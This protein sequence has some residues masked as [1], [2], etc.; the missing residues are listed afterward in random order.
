MLI[1]SSD[2]NH[3]PYSY[4]YVSSFVMNI[5]I[6]TLRNQSYHGLPDHRWQYLKRS[7]CINKIKRERRKWRKGKKD[8]KEDNRQEKRRKMWSRRHSAKVTDTG[9]SGC[10]RDPP[11]R[12]WLT[13]LHDDLVTACVMSREVRTGYDETTSSW[14]PVFEFGSAICGT[15]VPAVG[16]GFPSLGIDVGRKCQLWILQCQ[17]WVLMCQLWVGECQL[18]VE[19]C[20]L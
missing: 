3:L 5:I 13:D 9:S 2:C 10:W 8:E 11:T 7:I 4:I 1:I 16:R 18:W 15:V 12:R 17:L 14:V 20:Q 19:Q 6:I